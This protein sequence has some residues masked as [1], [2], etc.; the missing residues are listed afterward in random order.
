MAALLPNQFSSN[1]VTELEAG[2]LTVVQK[3]GESFLRPLDLILALE[4]IGAQL[5]FSNTWENEQG[6]VKIATRMVSAPAEVQYI[7]FQWR[8]VMTTE[9]LTETWSFPIEFPNTAFAIV[10]SKGAGVSERDLAV[11]ATIEDNTS[12]RLTNANNY[13]NPPNK[14]PVTIFAIGY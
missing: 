14:R 10:A 2:D 9:G 11:G 8:R 13:N 7:Y 6:Y 12:F 3:N 5:F 4:G 1:T